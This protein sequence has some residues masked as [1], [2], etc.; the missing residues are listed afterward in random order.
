MLTITEAAGAHMAEV[1]ADT[2]EDFAIR[3][4]LAGQNLEPQLDKPRSGDT[5]FDHNGRTVLIL[6]E[7]VSQMLAERTLDMQ[8]TH[9]GPR[10]MLS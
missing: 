4:V 8:E 9:E 5:T 10:L 2:Q 3:F 6:D 7:D 1:L